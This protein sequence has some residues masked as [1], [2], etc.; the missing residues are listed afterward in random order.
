VVSAGRQ[1]PRGPLF[2]IAAP[3]A[4]C[5]GHLDDLDMADAY[6]GLGRLLE[7]ESK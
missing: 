5:G 3:A 2:P 6:T 7:G 1:L 4:A